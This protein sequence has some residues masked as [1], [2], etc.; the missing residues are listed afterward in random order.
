MNFCTLTVNFVCE[1]FLDLIIICLFP[2]NWIRQIFSGV[3]EL[4]KFDEDMVSAAFQ[5]LKKSPLPSGRGG[6]HPAALGRGQTPGRA[7]GFQ[8]WA[9]KCWRA[10]VLLC[11]L[12]ETALASE[13]V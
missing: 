8:I 13:A 10:C 4:V 7:K 2:T 1:F 12:T 11:L 5:R 9:N 3:M 6:T